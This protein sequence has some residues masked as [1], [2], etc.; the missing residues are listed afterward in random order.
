[1]GDTMR[2]SQWFVLRRG[3]SDGPFDEATIVAWINDGMVDAQIRPDTAPPSFPWLS[4]DTHEPF[5]RGAA[6]AHATR[7]SGAEP[8]PAAQPHCRA[9]TTAIHLDDSFRSRVWRSCG[10]LD[11]SARRFRGPR[12]WP[13]AGRARS[14]CNCERARG[15]LR[16]GVS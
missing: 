7:G 4:L 14:A 8:T 3:E 1:M 5:R 9:S 6:R 10:A 13:A 16:G 15:R 11:R 2:V 12:G